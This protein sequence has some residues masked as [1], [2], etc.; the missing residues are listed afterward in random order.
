MGSNDTGCVVLAGADKGPA[1]GAVIESKNGRL[2]VITQTG[3]KETWVEDRIIFVTT[4]KVPVHPV[5]SAVA[6]LAAFWNRVDILIKDADLAGAWELLAGEGDLFTAAAVAELMFGNNG[7]EHQAAAAWTL[8]QDG[9]YFKRVKDGRYQPYSVKAVESAMTVKFQGDQE[10]E[11]MARVC[12]VLVEKMKAGESV[13]MADPLGAAGVGWLTGLVY[14]GPE[15]RDGKRGIALVE[16]LRGGDSTGEP[17]FVA[18]EYLV[19]LGILDEN[20]IISI[21]RNRIS[22]QFSPAV[23][24]EAEMLAG[25]VSAAPGAV[26]LV[27][28]EGGCGPLAIDDIRT[29]DVDD[30][31]MVEQVEGAFRVH[32]LVADP[33]STISLE[34]EVGR[35]GMSRASSLYVP[36]GTIPMFPAV[37]SEGALSLSPGGD[38]PML[39]FVVTVTADGEQVDFKIV[40]VV[41]RIQARVTY[42]EVDSILGDPASAGT[43][44]EAL[45]Q[46]DTLAVVLRNKRLAE[47]A[48]ILNRD[49]YSV[50]LVDG[51]PVVKRISGTSRSRGLVAEFMILAG[52]V[53]GGFARQN[54]IPVVYR[55]Q[56]APDGQIEDRLKGIPQDS[57]AMAYT[58]LRSMKRGELTT[59]PGFH[60]SL[61]VVG[62]TQVTSPLRR[63]QDFVA[64]VQIKGFLQDGVA[65]IDKDRLLVMFGELENR[66]EILTKV[67]REARRYWVLKY[68]QAGL[69]QQV[70]GEVVAQ[71]GARALVELDE[72][73]LVLPVPGAGRALPGSRLRM[74][75]RE[76]D[77]RRDRVTL[78]LA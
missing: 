46:L 11:R 45:R 67:E 65:P 32:I 58:L 56:D 63:F 40:P 57:K 20:E 34:S 52:A 66:T 77:P 50:Y 7:P 62:Y 69:G 18:F 35:A 6:G 76:V 28:P 29:K 10:R 75:V 48:V 44:S 19:R 72:T 60:F 22:T 24:V 5:Q 54:N 53:A 73:G 23:D 30:A 33:S 70:E 43:V 38:R 17:E 68:L 36:T 55:R 26:R 9:V 14:E 25:K 21:R 12:E 2:T 4:V 13:D 3:S 47:G 41:G 8:A 31:L 37:L 51:E 49:E 71:I 39:D 61:G 74:V 64:H 15:G 78:N 1:F 59:I 16:A 42:D 27:W